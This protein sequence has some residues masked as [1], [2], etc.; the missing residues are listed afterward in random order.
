MVRASQAQIGR[1][2]NPSVNRDFDRRSAQ[3][4]PHGVTRMSTKSR[5]TKSDWISET[6]A[7]QPPIMT[8]AEASILLRMHE[9][10]IRRL[11]S[12]GRMTAIKNADRGSSRV[13][14]PRAEVERYLR[15]VTP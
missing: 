6:I 9:R 14:I 13:R 8:L 5:P 7:G 10:S 2:A 11:V 4:A 15:A 3:C 12:L 1:A